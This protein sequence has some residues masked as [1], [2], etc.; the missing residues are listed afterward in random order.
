MAHEAGEPSPLTPPEDGRPAEA[1]PQ[2]LAALGQLA[3]PDQEALLSPEPLVLE[4]EQP[5]PEAARRTRRFFV[6]WTAWK[7]VEIT[8]TAAAVTA[9]A[10][11]GQLSAVA[12][13]NRLTQRQQLV[14]LA[15][16]IDEEVAAVPSNAQYAARAVNRGHVLN[17]TALRRKY[18]IVGPAKKKIGS[19]GAS[20][21]A[22]Y[23]TRL[24]YNDPYHQYHA[25]WQQIADEINATRALPEDLD[26]VMV[27]FA[28]VPGA[29]PGRRFE[30]DPSPRSIG[31]N[32]PEQLDNHDFIEFMVSGD[33]QYI[34]VISYEGGGLNL[35]R[36][37]TL[38][39]SQLANIIENIERSLVTNDHAARDAQ[40]T[41]EQMD[42]QSR[43]LAR[44]FTGDFV[45]SANR[46]AAMSAQ[47]IARGGNEILIVAAAMWL[48]GQGVNLAPWGPVRPGDLSVVREWVVDDTSD[49]LAPGR[50]C[51]NIGK[52][53]RGHD[54]GRILTGRMRDA[55]ME[56]ERRALIEHPGLVIVPSE[57]IGLEQMVDFFT[58]FD[59]EGNPDPTRQ[60]SSHP[61]WWGIRAGVGDRY[62]ASLAIERNGRVVPLNEV[63][64][65][66]PVNWTLPRD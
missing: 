49:P 20:T 38:T 46:I 45:E 36:Q 63:V 37:M 12:L 11:A 64:Q 13:D 35:V 33:G 22:Q 28:N 30:G 40:E 43:D 15:K 60:N 7:G 39:T 27:Y 62:L 17:I 52:I 34:K 16:K 32:G 58:P 48:W 44:L 24:D 18:G 50:T 10:K 6:V 29:P 14:N 31:V 54:L 4:H 59:E 56:G 66:Y 41:F 9:A 2:E 47:S 65:T 26:E 51:L 21:G 53:R 25:A 55:Q 57:L 8:G 19:V 61:G 3:M 5:E 23:G 42:G 1:L